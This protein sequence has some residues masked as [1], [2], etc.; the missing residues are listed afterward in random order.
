MITMKN[1]LDHVSPYFP[2]E[3]ADCFTNKNLDWNEGFADLSGLFDAATF[4]LDKLGTRLNSYSDPSYQSLQNASESFYKEQLAKDNFEILSFAGS[5]AAISAVA[6]AF[7]ST[8]D[9]VFV[10][11]P[12]YDNAVV[13]FAAQT[14][15]VSFFEMRVKQN[16]EHFIDVCKKSQPKLIY[17]VNPNNPIGY[18]LEL[19]KI[20]ELAVQNQETV[21]LIDEA[22]IEFTNMLSASTLIQSCPNVFVTR[23][24]SKAFSLAAL[25]IGFLM[26]SPSN[27]NVI[28][29]V[30]NTKAIAYL[31]EVI[32]ANALNNP[33]YMKEYVVR[34]NDQ[35]Q[36]LYSFLI[37]KEKQFF[38]SDTNFV[39]INDREETIISKLKKHSINNRDRSSQMQEAGW[40]RLTLNPNL[41]LIEVLTS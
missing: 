31:S 35:K 9:E 16:F 24:M 41:N 2:S 37:E 7:L 40:F 6:R 11:H 29:K 17:I 5:D 23:T 28:K 4:D 10:A 12:S 30:R 32:A 33:L 1:Y 13:E 20:R 21:V 27:A 25:R 22:Y 36:E 34:V 18:S 15:Q 3:R 26:C 8:G 39:L 14:K 19:E 38:V